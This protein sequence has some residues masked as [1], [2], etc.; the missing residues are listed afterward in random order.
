MIRGEL[1]QA[2]DLY[3]TRLRDLAVIRND[4]SNLEVDTSKRMVEYREWTGAG[5]MT[6]IMRNFTYEYVSRVP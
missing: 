2:T 3:L 5:E 6:Y 1:Y 4:K